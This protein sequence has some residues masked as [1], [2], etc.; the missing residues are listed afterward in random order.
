MKS[1]LNS[2]KCCKKEKPFPKLM[3]SGITGNIYLMVKPNS[4]TCIHSG[5]IGA[6]KMGDISNNL[7]RPHFTDYEGSV[8]LCN[9]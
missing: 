4:G 2:N 8:T 1:V 5:G 7:T 3:E 9:D 6:Y